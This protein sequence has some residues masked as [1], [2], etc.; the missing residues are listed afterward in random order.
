MK[1]NIYWW[2]TD[3]KRQT[4]GGQSA[5]TPLTENMSHQNPGASGEDGCKVPLDDPVG[6]LAV[7]SDSKS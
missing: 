5:S 3:M 2:D 7:A 4:K 1:I 6:H